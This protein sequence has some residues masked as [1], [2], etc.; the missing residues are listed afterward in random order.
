MHIL[1]ILLVL[2]VAFPAFA[3]LVGWMLSAIFWLVLILVAV[4]VFGVLSH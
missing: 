1:L 3:R 2:M 4:A